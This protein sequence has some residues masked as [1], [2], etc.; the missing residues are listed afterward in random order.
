MKTIKDTKLFN[1]VKANP[2]WSELFNGYGPKSEEIP[3]L[4]GG[5]DRIKTTANGVYFYDI[6]CN[7]KDNSFVI[8]KSN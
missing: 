4:A 5:L 2:A 1:E 6:G 8:R 7:D 3:F